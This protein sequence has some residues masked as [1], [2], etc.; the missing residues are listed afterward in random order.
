MFLLSDFFTEQGNVFKSR[1]INLKE[2]TNLNK[3]V[4]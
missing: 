2:R 3:N 1:V 4:R